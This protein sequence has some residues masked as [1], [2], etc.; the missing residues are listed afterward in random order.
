MEIDG[1]IDEAMEAHTPRSAQAYHHL[2]AEHPLRSDLVQ[3]RNQAQEEIR[4]KIAELKSDAANQRLLEGYSIV[5]LDSARQEVGRLARFTERSGESAESSRGRVFGDSYPGVAQAEA[6]GIPA[7]D[8]DRY[9]QLN[10]QI[11]QLSG[12]AEVAHQSENAWRQNLPLGYMRG[13]A[14]L[15]FPGMRGGEAAFRAAKRGGVAPATAEFA[16]LA[17]RLGYG[18]MATGDG[19]AQR[20]DDA[21]QLGIAAE[22]DPELTATSPMPRSL[23]AL[24][25][26]KTAATIRI[27]EMLEAQGQQMAMQGAPTE[28]IQQ[29]MDTVQSA[30][31]DML[32]L[33]PDHA[34]D[35]MRAMDE[36]LPGFFETSPW[37]SLWNDRITDPQEQASYRLQLIR[38]KN[39]GRLSLAD[40]SKRLSKFNNGG[41]VR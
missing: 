32:A 27:Q 23:D 12:F 25:A 18:V 39:S 26:M 24:K 15:L 1:M 6:A 7:V 40:Y 31:A 36:M 17:S 11:S 20:L 10:R 3:L 14:S 41:S 22:V 4:D 16:K 13:G 29:Q 33:S 28:A 9:Q 21:I 35:Q 8:F 34:V 19:L 30:F 38:E 5:D 2:P 37:K